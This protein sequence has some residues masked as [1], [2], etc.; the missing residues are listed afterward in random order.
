MDDVLDQVRALEAQGLFL[1]A[2]DR[3][4][5]GIEAGVAGDALRHRAVLALAR[6][7]ATT[8]ALGLLRRL[9]LTGS[10]DP[11][12]AGLQ[13]RLLKD[14]ALETGAAQDARAAGAAYAALWRRHGDGWH[15]VNV[16]A[17]A[18]LANDREAARRAAAAVGRL[19]DAGDYWSA[20]TQAEASLLLGDADAAR[21]WLERAEARAGA[22]LAARAVTRRQLRWEAARLGIAQDLVETLVVPDALHYCGTI[23]GGPADEAALR[24][25]L[26][27]MLRGVGAAFGGL[28]AGADIVA[29]E[30]LVAQGA[31]LTVLLPFPPESYIEHSV[32]PAGEAWVGRFR[33]CLDRAKLH[34]LDD[35]HQDDLDYGLASRRAMGLARVHA[36]RLDARAW[37]LAI[38]DGGGTPGGAAGTATDVA[39][40]AAA[41][42][43]TRIVASPWPRRA[44][45][46]AMVTPDKPI[47]TPKAVLFSDLPN[48]SALDDRALLAF[49]DAQLAAMG[50]AVDAHA[51][52][53]RNAWGDAIQLAFDTPAAAASCAFAL[54]EAA[55]GGLMP[56]LALDYGGLHPVFDAVQQAP[57][58]A[59]R[60]MTRAARI[61]PVT[62]AGFVY[63]TEAFACEVA[64]MPG[65]R[66][67][68]DY[69]GQVPLAKN[70][71]VLPLYVVRALAAAHGAA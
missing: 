67:A 13:A 4:M 6:A 32:R 11:E 62:P 12:I 35:A 24:A 63:A 66:I 41:G 21:R 70:Y 29:A 33:A 48:F 58:F 52:V 19:P 36:R 26:A 65:A 20:A 46:G 60:V 40:W 37:Q 8:S 16:A 56:R 38:W 42:G 30:M 5:A 17:M 1:S 55:A 68:C 49:Y 18:L 69:A 9:G 54:R 71:G 50:R 45:T 28:A 57:K 59:G 23:P 39:A 7:G 14:V 53:Y 22:D 31:A 64:L 61:E 43:A 51:P 10:A 44:P 27:P 15:G 47:R 3:A 2:H 25:E 34:V